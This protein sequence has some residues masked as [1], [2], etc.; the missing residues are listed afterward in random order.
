[1]KV[2]DLGSTKKFQSTNE[3]KV[4]NDSILNQTLLQ[5]NKNTNLLMTKILQELQRSRQKTF[6]KRL[7][8]THKLQTRPNNHGRGCECKQC[9]KWNRCKGKHIY[10]KPSRFRCPQIDGNSSDTGLESESRRSP[11][12][13][14]P[15][16]TPVQEG[17]TTAGGSKLSLQQSSS[18]LKVGK[19]KFSRN[20]KISGQSNPFSACGPFNGPNSPIRK[21]KAKS[22]A[23]ELMK[24]FYDLIEKNKANPSGSDLEDTGSDYSEEADI[25]ETSDIQDNFSSDIEEEHFESAN[26]ALPNHSPPK[27]RPK[28]TKIRKDLIPLPSESGSDP[29]SNPEPVQ[30]NPTAISGL[31]EDK[32]CFVESFDLDINS[33]RVDQLAIPASFQQA[34]E[35]YFR[36][37]SKYKNFFKKKKLERY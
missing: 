4:D 7:N 18:T 26:S 35:Q 34:P 5:Q 32:I 22:A 11:A 10:G 14:D 28:K 2:P 36:F 20:N 6:E 27:S 15:S 24:A 30:C 13:H 21:R 12:T 1:M 8:V 16:Q 29:E 17:S 3:K 23:N 37:L 33:T 19:S 9:Y 25:E 31:D